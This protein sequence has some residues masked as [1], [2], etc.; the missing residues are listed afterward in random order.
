MLHK[1]NVYDSLYIDL[2]NNSDSQV[3]FSLQKMIFVDFFCTYSWYVVIFLSV[4][5]CFGAIF[6]SLW[7]VTPVH[8][9]GVLADDLS[10]TGVSRKSHHW[11][12]HGPSFYDVL[13]TRYFRW[14]TPP[15]PPWPLDPAELFFFQEY[16]MTSHFPQLDGLLFCG[17][18]RIDTPSA[19]T[20]GIWD[21]EASCVVDTNY[22]PI[23]YGNCLWKGF[24]W[25]KGRRL[26]YTWAGRGSSL[27]AV[28]GYNV[29]GDQLLP[30]LWGASHCL[31]SQHPP[32]S[33]L[34][35]TKRQFPFK[36]IKRFT[37]KYRCYC[38]NF[39][40]SL[41]DVFIRVICNADI[42]LWLLIICLQP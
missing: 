42:P 40:N 1:C 20:L 16:R 6:L 9:E 8:Q 35:K 25:V 36:F 24:G 21:R 23:V 14:F 32:A 26:W 39:M 12:I 4:I 37:I 30:V 29:V 11:A 3:S 22:Y 33:T 18:Q 19:G 15:P 34:W 7:R 2:L 41:T 5:W 13:I 31:C 28:P 27:P 10:C 38:E 17:E